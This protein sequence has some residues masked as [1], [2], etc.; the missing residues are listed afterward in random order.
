MGR[1]RKKGKKHKKHLLLTIQ[2]K[3]V[4][5]PSDFSKIFLLAYISCTGEFHCEIYIYPYNVS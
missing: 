3:G 5:I 2:E 1:N 4:K